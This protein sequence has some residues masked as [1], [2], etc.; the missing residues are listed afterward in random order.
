[1]WCAVCDY[2]ETAYTWREANSKLS[3]NSIEFQFRVIMSVLMLYEYLYS[4][5]NSHVDVCR[6]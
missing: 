6:W 3:G 5:V 1:M 4:Y 2:L